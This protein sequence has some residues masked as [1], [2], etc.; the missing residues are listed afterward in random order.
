[1]IDKKITRENITE[2]LIDSMLA[3]IGKTRVEMVEA[4]NYKFDF[5]MTR[6]QYEAFYRYSI[7]VLQKT[8]HF[9]KRKAISNFDWWWKNFGIRIKN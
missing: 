3:L 6:A 4:F 8:F 9:N 7:F 5:T 1:M 2:S